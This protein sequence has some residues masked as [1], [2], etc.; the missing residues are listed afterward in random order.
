MAIGKA[1]ATGA[2]ELAIYM[3]VI[4]PRMNYIVDAIVFAEGE[5]KSDF[6]VVRMKL[7]VLCARR[8]SKHVTRDRISN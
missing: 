7:D 4:G 3:W 6:S 8:S 2:V 5:D 1:D